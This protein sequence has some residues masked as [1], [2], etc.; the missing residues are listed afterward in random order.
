M[1]NKIQNSAVLLVLLCFAFSSCGVIFG[2]S[3][4]AASIAV[5]DHPKAMISVNGNDLGKGTAVGVFKRSRPL[6]ITVNEPGCKEQTKTFDNTFRT[7][8]FILSLVWWGLL[9]VVV[10]LGTGA[11]F[12]PDHKHDPRITKQTT[13]NFMFTVDYTGCEN[14]VVETIH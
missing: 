7:G 5:K 8:N 3:R 12:K 4:Y 14:T 13:K 2:G 6:A 11:S 1:K 10:D 9:G